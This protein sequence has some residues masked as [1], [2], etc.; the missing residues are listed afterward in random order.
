ML[1]VVEFGLDIYLISS[2]DNYVAE[3][4]DKKTNAIF[5][6]LGTESTMITCI[7][8]KYYHFIFSAG[9][10]QQ[11]SAEFRQSKCCYTTELDVNSAKQSYFS[12]SGR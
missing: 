2:S 4:A 6:V 3:S 5:T 9:N 8:F 10:S 12:L 7:I 1:S 11:F